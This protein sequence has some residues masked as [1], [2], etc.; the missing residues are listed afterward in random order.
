VVVANAG[1][2]TLSVIDVRADKVVETIWAK[3]SPAELFGAS[4][5]AMAFDPSGDTLYVANG[6]QNAIAVFRFHP[7]ES[8]LL[9]LIPVGWFPARSRTTLPVA[10]WPL[11]N[12][13]GVGLTYGLKE[14]ERTS[15]TRI[16]TTGRCRSFRSQRKRNCPR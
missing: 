15:T 3:S 9:G 13:K 4:P 11:A 8:K 12:I 2:D 14:R 7:D 1:S 5:N 6:T 16:S 10:A